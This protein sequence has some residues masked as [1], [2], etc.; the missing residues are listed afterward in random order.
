M[1]LLRHQAILSCTRI[2][3]PILTKLDAVQLSGLKWAREL[4]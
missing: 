3:G 1:T 4:L 2:R